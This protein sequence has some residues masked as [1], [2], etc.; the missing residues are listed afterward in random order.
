M[1]FNPKE[2]GICLHYS[3]PGCSEESLVNEYIFRSPNVLSASFLYLK[4]PH[5]HLQSEVPLWIQ[6]V[7]KHWLREVIL[8]RSSSQ[9][10]TE[11]GFGA[12]G[13]SVWKLGL[14]PPWVHGQITMRT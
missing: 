14:C 10:G 13:I 11:Q 4:T 8:P 3:G 1:S 6:M 7:M 9:E 2:M 5:F 12:L